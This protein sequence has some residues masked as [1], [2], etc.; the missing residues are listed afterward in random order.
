MREGLVVRL[1]KPHPCGANAWEIMRLGMDVKLRCGGCGQIVRLP[2]KKFE[3]RVREVLGT[4]GVE[5][6]ST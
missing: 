2:R 5:D 3:R 1:K 4:D 6:Q